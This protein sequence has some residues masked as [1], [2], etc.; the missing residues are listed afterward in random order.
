MY[1]LY[2]ITGEREKEGKRKRGS[3]SQEVKK[4]EMSEERRGEG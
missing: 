4:E 1:L 3:G 2:F